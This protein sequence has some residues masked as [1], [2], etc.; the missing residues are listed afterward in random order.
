MGLYP[1]FAFHAI[2]SIFH[3]ILYIFHASALL[4]PSRLIVKLT[5]MLVYISTYYPFQ[6]VSTIYISMLFMILQRKL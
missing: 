6:L 3:T 4:I 5:N 2:L 1:L